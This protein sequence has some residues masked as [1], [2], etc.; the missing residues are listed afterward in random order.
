[1]STEKGWKTVFS[2]AIS[3]QLLNAAV[4]ESLGTKVV[5]TSLEEKMLSSIICSS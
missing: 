1:M 4:N 3:L 5:H 2:A